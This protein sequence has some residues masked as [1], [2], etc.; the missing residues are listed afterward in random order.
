MRI[1]T[2]QKVKMSKDTITKLILV[3]NQTALIAARL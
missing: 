1:Y 2:G 3:L